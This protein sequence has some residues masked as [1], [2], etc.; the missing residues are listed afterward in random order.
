M[1]SLKEIVKLNLRNSK[2]FSFSLNFFF[3]WS[4]SFDFFYVFYKNFRKIYNKKKKDATG[5]VGPSA[6]GKVH[7]QVSFVILNSIWSL[8]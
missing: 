2:L 8:I 6:N 3:K 4:C 1:L 7:Q 5:K